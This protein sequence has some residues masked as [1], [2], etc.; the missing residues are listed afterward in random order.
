MAD[1]ECKS[2]AMALTA[3]NTIAA[4][5]KGTQQAAIL[6]VKAWIQE[7]VPK[8]FPSEE[9]KKIFEYVTEGERKGRE[10]YERGSR[11]V[12]G[13]WVSTEPEEGAEW[14]CVWNAKNKQ[15]QPPYPPPLTMG[16]EPSG[17]KAARREENND[18][19][20]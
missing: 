13:E 4:E 19:T 18:V 5:L 14:T 10:W 20:Q 16:G 3:L 8:E 12:N 15:W 1:F 6:A 11:K 2:V 7:N 17:A 9:L